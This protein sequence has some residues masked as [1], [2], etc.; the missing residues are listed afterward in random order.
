MPQIGNGLLT[1]EGEYWLK[2]RRAIQ[3]AFHRG[4]LEYISQVM[5]DEIKVFMDETLERYSNSGESF[6]I[7]TEIMHLAFKLVSSLFLEKT[8]KT[9]N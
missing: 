2:Q 9:I 7:D 8:Q 3:P 4:K 5:S 6:Q 1:S